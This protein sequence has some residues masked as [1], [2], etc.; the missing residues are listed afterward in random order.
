MSTSLHPQLSFDVRPHPASRRDDGSPPY[1]QASLKVKGDFHV[2]RDLQ[3]GD[4]L[5]VTIADADGEVVASGLSEVGGVSF[6]LI[7]EKGHVI[8]TER[9]HVTELR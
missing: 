5:T 3:P 7:K 4:E 8:G 2:S 1:L 9:A 6:P